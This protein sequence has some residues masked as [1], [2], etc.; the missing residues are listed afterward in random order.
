[1]YIV[2]YLG[3]EERDDTSV[4]LH[5]SRNL[6]DKT[7]VLKPERKICTTFQGWHNIRHLYL[8]IF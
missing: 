6:N 8:N 5:L 1:M 2:Q 3:V 4:Q 7:R